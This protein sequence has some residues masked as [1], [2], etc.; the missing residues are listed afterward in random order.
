MLDKLS[1]WS[2]KALLV[3]GILVWIAIIGGL[4]FELIT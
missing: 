2:I 3:I 1:E 4:L